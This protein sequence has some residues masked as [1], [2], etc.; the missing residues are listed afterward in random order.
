MALALDNL[1]IRICHALSL[2][3]VE[4]TNV[5]RRYAATVRIRRAHPCSFVDVAASVITGTPAKDD[6]MI[7]V[8]RLRDR[9]TKKLIAF[10]L[11][12]IF[13]GGTFITS[14]AD[15]PSTRCYQVNTRV[16]FVDI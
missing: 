3:C 12:N 2:C 10:L 14:S 4:N 8:R 7:R 1:V 5:V 16:N 13:D 15:P 6:W 11:P 9:L